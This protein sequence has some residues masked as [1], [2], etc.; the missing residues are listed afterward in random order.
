MSSPNVE[1]RKKRRQQTV[2]RVTRGVYHSC[3]HQEDATLVLYLHVMADDSKWK[4]D[5][6][7]FRSRYLSQLEKNVRER[8]S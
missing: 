8:T 2:G 5:N 3:I 1:I 4:W 7:T 6:D